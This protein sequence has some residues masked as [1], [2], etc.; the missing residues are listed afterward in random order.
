MLLPYNCPS[1]G[2]ARNI[3][4]MHYSHIT[5]CCFAGLQAPKDSSSVPSLQVK[6][7]EALGE[8]AVVQ[9]KPHQYTATVRF[10]IA[11]VCAV[12][13]S[14]S[15]VTTFGHILM[16]KGWFNTTNASIYCLQAAHRVW[17]IHRTL[18]LDVGACGGALGTRAMTTHI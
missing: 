15:H 8:C 10:F 16:Y 5:R 4:S 6:A 2:P 13:K 12:C 3:L 18:S 11:S 9:S 17:F 7:P 14:E 1:R